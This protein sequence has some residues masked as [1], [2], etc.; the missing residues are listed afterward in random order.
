MSNFDEMLTTLSACDAGSLAGR[1]KDLV[2]KKVW[3]DSIVELLDTISLLSESKSENQEAFGANGAIAAVVSILGPFL[4]EESAG[5]A[6]D[7]ASEVFLSTIDN[8]VHP[9]VVGASIRCIARLCRRRMEKSTAND[10][11]ISLLESYPNSLEIIAAA[12][13]RALTSETVALYTCWLVMILASDSPERQFKLV[14]TGFHVIVIDAMK[15]HIHDENIAEMSC[16]A[17]RNIAAAESDIVAKFVEDGICE[18]IAAVLRWYKDHAVVTEAALWAIV[19]LSCEENVATILGSVGIVTA[20][21]ESASLLINLSGPTLAACSAIRN[22][23][24]AGALNYSLFSHT[25]VC[26]VVHDILLLHCHPE[27][28]AA[29]RGSSNSTSTG[30]DD[31]TQM[32]A[33]AK[34]YQLDHDIAETAL[35]AAANL[36]CDQVGNDILTRHCICGF[37]CFV[38]AFSICCPVGYNT[39]SSICICC[40]QRCVCFHVLFLFCCF[41]PALLSPHAAAIHRN[42]HKH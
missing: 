6:T 5:A 25:E 14:S 9:A 41:T 2:A 35:W 34:Q 17:A 26:R 30:G 20:V 23:S 12:A 37:G 4:R 22:L 10:T 38:Y 28:Y 19:N 18:A 31:A 40:L 21:V 32:T 39:G 16:R 15:S 13:K 29:V 27:G 7:G 3:D 24:S 8:N 42:S 1:L 36:A 33:A 11:N